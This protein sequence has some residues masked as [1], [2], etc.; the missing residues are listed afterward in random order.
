M[1]R[2]TSSQTLSEEA[3]ELI[4]ARF[5]E[6]GEVNR[7]RLIVTVG[8]GEKNVSQLV[9]ATGLTQANV[10]RHLQSL[11]DAGIL[12]RRKEGT[13]VFYSTADLTGFDLCEIVGTSLKKRLCGQAK[14]FN[15]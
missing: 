1:P 9:A 10:S 3:I 6:L 7:L 14:V 15:K 5:R 13:Y 12:V 4:A 2:N 11:T 8:T